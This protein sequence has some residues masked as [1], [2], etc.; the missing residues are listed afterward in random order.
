MGTGFEIRNSIQKSAR[1]KKYTEPNLLHAYH[2]REINI[3]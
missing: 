1:F 3:R 2:A